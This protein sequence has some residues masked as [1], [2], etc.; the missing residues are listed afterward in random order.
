MQNKVRSRALPYLD[1]RLILRMGIFT[2]VSLIMFGVIVFEMRQNTLAILW[3]AAGILFGFGGGL[4]A[5]RIFRLKWNEETS[6][7]IA[8][9]DWIGGV[10]LVLYLAFRLL[11]RWLSGNW[12]HGVA[13]STFFLSVSAGSML[14]RLTG[15]GFSIRKILQAQ[16][17]PS[18]N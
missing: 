8:Q 13:L 10:I 5:S 9:I 16:N 4:V 1:R 11:L 12:L 2:L 3:A 17:V 6:R 18:K 14:G 7:V 15:L